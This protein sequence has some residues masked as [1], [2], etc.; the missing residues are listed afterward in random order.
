MLENALKVIETLAGLLTASA[1]II[2]S[3][4]AYLVFKHNKDKDSSND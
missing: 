3:V 2:T 1:S 4:V